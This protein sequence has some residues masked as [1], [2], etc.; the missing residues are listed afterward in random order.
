[1]DAFFN[2]LGRYVTGL[3]DELG[4]IASRIDGSGWC[5]ISGVLLVCGWFWL[6]G[7]KVRGA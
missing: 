6:R 2:S 4:D 1:M 5:A 3:F 7:N